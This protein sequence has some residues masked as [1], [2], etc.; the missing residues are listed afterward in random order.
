MKKLFRNILFI[1][2]VVIVVASDLLLIT[3]EEAFIP[4]MCVSFP[5]TLY[6]F[7]IC[8]IVDNMPLT[9]C[10]E[11]ADE[12]KRYCSA[13]FPIGCFVTDQSIPRDACVISVSSSLMR[14]YFTE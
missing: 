5:P 11:V 6:C 14:H 4:C 9:W 7:Y 12:E 1:H 10:Y 3:Q 13:S 2:H 8:R